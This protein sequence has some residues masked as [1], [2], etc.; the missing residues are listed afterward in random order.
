MLSIKRFWKSLALAI[1]ALVLLAAL[2]L[3]PN[4]QAQVA[5]SYLQ[6]TN[7]DTS[8][9]PNVTVTIFGQ[10]LTDGLEQ[11]DLELREDGVSQELDKDQVEEVGV[12][13]ALVIDASANITNRGQTGKTRLEEVRDAVGDLTQSSRLL[14]GKDYLSAMA[15]GRE[16]NA[17]I[18]QILAP[19][20]TDHQGVINE[21]FALQPDPANVV[22]PLFQQIF[23]ALDLFEDASLPNNLQR[24]IVVFSDGVDILSGTEPDDL[25]RRASALNVRIHTVWFRNGGAGAEAN[26]R[27]IAQLTGGQAFIFSADNPIPTNIW[28]TIQSTQNQRVISYR[29]TNPNPQ[30]LT[31]A[32]NS[33]TGGR[34]STE[35]VFPS[36]RVLPAQIR[37]VKPGNSN[38]TRTGPLWNTKVGDLTPTTL[39]GQVEILW[40][41]GR[42]RGI[43]L[44]YQ[45][46]GKFLDGVGVEVEGSLLNLVLPIADLDEGNHTL[47][48]RGTDE[49]GLIGESAPVIL[50]VIVDKPL[51]PPTPNAQATATAAAVTRIAD[52]NAAATREANIK[53]TADA[54][55]TGLAEEAAV[56]AA[57]AAAT[58]DARATGAAMAAANSAAVAAATADAAIAAQATEAAIAAA[59]TEARADAQATAAAAEL[60]VVKVDSEAQVRNLSYV[61]MISTALGLAALVFA[62]VAWRN[63]RVRKRATE[64]VSGTIQAVTEPFFGSRGGGPPSSAAK[65]R[66]ILV[67]GDPSMNQT[68]EIYKEVT[69]LGRDAALVDVVINDRRISRYHGQIKEERGGFRLLDEGSTSGTW[70]NDRQIDMAGHLLHSGDEINFG[71][72]R[73]RFET[74][75]SEPTV[76]S[77]GGAMGEKTEPFVPVVGGTRPADDSTQIADYGQTGMDNATQYDMSNLNP[78]DMDSTQYMVPDEDDDD[79]KENQLPYH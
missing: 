14:D 72:I 39:P 43:T 50:N 35:Q 69:K 63:P 58:A 77:Y 24:H 25:P 5:S 37:I 9:F 2:F 79:D 11:A 65:A 4:L 18:P 52:Q 67:N 42:S 46:D 55:A 78:S 20:S 30:R 54:R 59:T 28:E 17:P 53:A 19:W 31:I 6:I 15:F 66:L 73:Y 36:V 61:S 40:P 33:A 21:I 70:V 41:D 56:A 74:T 29:T 22:T 68:I 23:A 27:R 16:D 26:M 49:F 45:I 48:I 34:L 64:F 12:Q 71:P 8:N 32:A 60:Q 7:I 3:S 47:R 38:L 62:V 51:P 1:S 44:E 75:S 13:I 76:A 57:D 10:G